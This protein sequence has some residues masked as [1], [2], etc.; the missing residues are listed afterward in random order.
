MARSK[1]KSKRRR[2]DTTDIARTRSAFVDP[3]NYTVRPVDLR[4]FED[5]RTYHPEG[6]N[7]PIRSITRAASR[8]GL[9]DSVR[10]SKAMPKKRARRA[11]SV[12]SH[13]QTRD[14]LVFARPKEVMTCVRRTERREVIFAKRKAGRGS[15]KKPKFDFRSK[16]SC[17]K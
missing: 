4:V 9:R 7:R 12:P 11:P 14:V 10:P 15:R 17:K 5:R 1:S 2:R 13:G 6:K 8:V 16:I 3:D